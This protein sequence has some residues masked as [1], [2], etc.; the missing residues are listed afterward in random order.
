MKK[1]SALL[2]LMTFMMSG[3]IFTSCKKGEIEKKFDLT[4]NGIV[5]NSP[6]Q[7]GSA[8]DTVFAS[9]VITTGIEAKLNENGAT[10]QNIKK[11]DLK[12]VSL[13][14]TT[15]SGQTFDGIEYLVS[16]INAAGLGETKVAYKSPIPQTGLT[17]ITQDSQFSDLTEYIKQSEF[18]FIL[19]GYSNTAIP[20]MTL[21]ADISFSITAMV[22]K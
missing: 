8:P 13:S 16:Y 19:K 4:L 10:L 21:T 6:A 3:I 18:N 12:S 20:A 9:Q 2:M 7:P 11:I 5:L 17:T 15:P 22:S 14:I 1:I